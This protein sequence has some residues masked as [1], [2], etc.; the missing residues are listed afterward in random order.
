MS[1]KPNFIVFVTDQ[2]RADWLGCYGHPVV[3]TPNIDKIASTGTVFNNF[4]VAAPLCMPNRA[5]LLTGRYP[6]VHGL[7]YNGCLLPKRARTFVEILAHNGYDTA[8]IGKSHLQP[9]TGLNANRGKTDQ[10]EAWTT[11]ESDYQLEE[12]HKYALDEYY[13]FPTPYYGYN[14]V[15]MVTGHGTTCNGHYRQWLRHKSDDWQALI[16][17]SNQHP[18]DYTCPQAV[19]TKLPEDLYPTTYIAN[20]AVEY[21]TEQLEKDTPSFTFISFPDPHHP[22][23][24]PGKY[25]DMYQPDEFE[26]DTKYEDHKQPPK[27]LQFWKNQYLQGKTDSNKQM[28]FFAEEQEIKQAMA[29]TAGMITMIDD[30]IGDIMEVV[31]NSAAANNTVVCF[32]A[33]HGDYMGDSNLLLKASWLRQSITRVPFI[34][35]D[36]QQQQAAYCDAPFGTIDIATSIL[37]RAG[38]SIYHGNQGQSFLP[39]LTG[40][41][42]EQRSMLIESNDPIPRFGFDKP[43]RARQILHGHWSMTII[44]G[45][46]DGELYDRSM[47]PKE[48]NNLWHEPAYQTQKL[49]L[50]TE[51]TH[52][53]TQQMDES[54][55]ATRFA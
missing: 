50:M 41:G 54:P 9:F 12:P 45:E 23:N 3:K 13:D 8:A 7:R 46:S 36:P 24:P 42:D 22:F 10:G 27:H 35:T 5:S 2:H 37:E 32:T 25:W 40:A 39:G 11:D 18:H 4:Q 16:E 6:S 28:A 15:D 14:H 20:S 31:N 55:A 43:I 21:L 49:A 19:R 52:L 29:L 53:L 33:D 38:L 47:D 44:E 1:D 17:P 51:L 34:W 48:T 26:L 30:A